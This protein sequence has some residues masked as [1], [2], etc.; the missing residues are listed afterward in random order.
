MA[1]ESSDS[2]HS[3]LLALLVPIGTAPVMLM[4][5]GDPGRA[6][7]AWFCAI[8]LVISVQIFWERRRHLWFWVMVSILTG[9]H[10]LLVLRV[11]WPSPHTTI[12]GPAFVPVGLLDVG[13]TC[14]CFKLVET[15]RSK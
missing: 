11:P 5:H 6:L 1:D 10:V 12:G 15:L 2:V 9:L 8:A 14:G 3:R 4:F 13:I 7:A